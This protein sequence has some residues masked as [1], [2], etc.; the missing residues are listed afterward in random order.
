MLR[1]EAVTVRIGQRALLEDIDIAITPGEVLGILGPNGAGKSTLLRCLS[2][3]RRP[4]TGRVTLDDTPIQAISPRDL[5]RR[6]AV[7]SQHVDL[8]FPFTALEVV[9][10]GRAPH[11]SRGARR[12][13]LAAL[14]QVGAASL[15]GQRWPS[16]SGGEKQRVQLA[17]ALVQIRE[18]EPGISR[19]LLLDEPTASLDLRHQHSTLSLARRL[20]REGVGVGVILHD[21][22][23][24]MTYTDRL[25]LL[26]SGQSIAQGSTAEI[27]DAERIEQAFSLPVQI[28]P[29]PG[30]GRLVAAMT[31]PKGA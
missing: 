13:A 18:V 31:D 19:Y 12:I 29:H 16:L 6:R 23:L 1:A 17:R 7:L 21:L 2:G 5:A 3:T 22:N 10:L 8:R 27:L 9:A 20:S 15:A 4:T 30:G 25:L 26:R 28:L 24:A 11:G 14:E